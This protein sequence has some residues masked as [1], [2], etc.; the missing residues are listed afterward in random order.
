MTFKSLY[1]DFISGVPI[2]REGWKG[3]WK[4]SYGEIMMHCKDGTV[5]NIK[6]TK[7]ILFTISNIF[8]NDWEIVNIEVRGDV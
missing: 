7:D 2:R 6:D 4:Y 5:L 1:P 8:Q 3:Y